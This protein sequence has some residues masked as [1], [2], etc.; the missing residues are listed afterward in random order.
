M[1]EVSFTF[2]ARTQ[3]EGAARQAQAALETERQKAEALR[4]YGTFCLTNYGDDEFTGGLYGERPRA[5]LWAAFD[6]V[7][8]VAVYNPEAERSYVIGDGTVQVDV[9]NGIHTLQQ[10]YARWMLPEIPADERCVIF[11]HPNP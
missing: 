5:D 9:I 11:L 1:G 4:A 10:P 7:E 2:L 3:G 8:G 6:D